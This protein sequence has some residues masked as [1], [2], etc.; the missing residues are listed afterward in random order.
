MGLNFYNK[1]K[2]YDNCA[3]AGVL[4]PQIKIEKEWYEKV[5]L[6]DG[7]SN[8]DFLKKL[9]NKGF[10]DR[11]I[12]KLE[13]KQEYIDRTKYELEVFEELSFIDYVLLNWSVL[14]WCHENKIPIGL[15]RGSAAGSLVLYLIGVTGIDPIKHGLYFERFVSKS[16]SRK[17]EKNGTTYLDGSLLADVDNDIA[18]D[19]RYEV[20]EFIKQKHPNR[21]CHILNLSSL[22]GKICIKE[23]GKIVAEYSEET[24]NEVSDLIPKHFGKVAKFKDAVK[25]EP[26]FGKW[27]ER[28]Q[29]VFDIA[30]KL[31]GLI[32]NVGVHASGILI[33]NKELTDICPVQKTKEGALVSC[34]DMYLAAELAVK[35]DILGLKTLTVIKDCCD[36]IGKDIDEIDFYDPDIYKHFQV[37]DT[38]EGLF[39]IEADTNYRVCRDVKPRNVDELAAV[40]S[41]ARPGALAFVDTYA[42]YVETGKIEE[43]DIESDKLKE[44]IRETG[45]TIIFQETLMQIAHRVF[46]LTLE[47]AESLRR[48]IGKKVREKMLEFEEIIKQKGEELGIPKSAKFYWDALIASADYSF[49]KCVFEEELVELEGGRK[50]MLK[51]VKIGDRIKAFDTS[52]QEDIIV[53][54]KNVY[55]NKQ[56]LYETTVESGKTIRTSIDHKFLGKDWVMRPLH[57]YYS[58]YPRQMPD[59]ITDAPHLFDEVVMI[60][61]WSDEKMNTIDLEVDHPDHNFYCNG[62]VVS[63]SHAVS[64]AALAAKTVY[65]KF[66]HTLEFFAALLRNS[67][68]EQDPFEIIDKVSKELKIFGIKLLPPDLSKS[69]M[70]FKVEGENIRYGLNSI[71]GVS[72]KKLQALLDFREVE[73]DNK[74]DVFVAAKNAGLDIGVLSSLIQAGTLNSF[75]DDRARMVYEAQVFNILTDR[76]KRNFV[77]LGAK[78]NYDIFHIWKNEVNGPNIGDDQKPLIKESRKKTIQE[79][80]AKYKQIYEKNKQNKDFANWYFERKLL[81]FCYTNRLKDLYQKSERYLGLEEA[82]NEFNGSRFYVIGVVKEC[83][84]YTSKKSGKKYMRINLSDEF[85]DLT[86]FVWQEKML[87]LTADGVNIDKESIISAEVQKMDGDGASVQSVAVLDDKIF[88]KLSDVK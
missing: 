63:N 6:E 64:Y 20:I 21:T 22:S 19:K 82:I 4:L 48:S 41:L 5:G 40:V 34:Y 73:T 69:D 83:K 52:N 13:N 9:C 33:S 55:K 87:Q 39:Q 47:Q 79:K 46:G 80:T 35:F 60:E 78:Y 70:D 85:A 28:N 11:G 81:G 75:N 14:S 88:M 66:N 51:D 56:Y 31:E 36:H 29:E 53:T 1:F 27:A 57:Y 77:N 49:N 67:K 61:R 65:L 7:A 10:V 59:C 72:E 26:K 15:S 43:V 32:K 37:L 71:K 62:F 18:F 24:M 54:V 23:V 68:Y 76:E 58:F 2:K 45:N 50:I 84:I 8:V 42:Q 38:K 17:I 74:F 3:P 30:V 25:E 16:R 86:C 44:I 12:S